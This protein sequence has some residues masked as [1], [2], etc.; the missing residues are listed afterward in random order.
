MAVDDGLD[1]GAAVAGANFSNFS[2]ASL[3]SNVSMMSAT[4]EDWK[5]KGRRRIGW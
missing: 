4:L 5:D 3:N 2:A 1:F